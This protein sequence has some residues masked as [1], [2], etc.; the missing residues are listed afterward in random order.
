MKQSEHIKC[1]AYVNSRVEERMAETYS[2][3]IHARFRNDS[4]TFSKNVRLVFEI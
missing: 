3:E 4:N 1:R 2:Q